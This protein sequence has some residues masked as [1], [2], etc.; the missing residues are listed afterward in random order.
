MIKKSQFLWKKSIYIE[1]DFD[2]FRLALEINGPNS[3]QIVATI[4][5]YGWNGIKKV[6]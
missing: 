5:S 2:L 4:K 6:D 3:N 1:K